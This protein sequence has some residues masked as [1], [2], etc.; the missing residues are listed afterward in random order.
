MLIQ[1]APGPDHV[2]G[3]PA[4]EKLCHHDEQHE[5]APASGSVVAVVVAA[6]VADAQL[7]LLLLSFV[8]DRVAGGDVACRLRGTVPLRSQRVISSLDDR[9][10]FVAV[11]EG[12]ALWFLLDVALLLLLVLMLML[13]L[14][15]LLG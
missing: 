9:V 1:E 3:C 4:D 5:H 7:L 8:V 14:V 6:V 2:Q 15:L 11:D 13:L 12:V 10:G